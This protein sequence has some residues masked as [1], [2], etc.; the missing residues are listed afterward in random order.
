VR[1]VLLPLK[2]TQSHEGKRHVI[3]LW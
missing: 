3:L 2:K 1:V